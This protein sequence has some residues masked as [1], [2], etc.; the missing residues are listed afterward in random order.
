[1]LQPLICS[2]SLCYS[3]PKKPKIR[4]LGRQFEQYSAAG[5]LFLYVIPSKKFFLNGFRQAFYY[6]FFRAAL[7]PYY[8]EP[9]MLQTLK[10]IAV[11]IVK[12]I[13]I[14]C[15]SYSFFC[16]PPISSRIAWRHINTAWLPRTVSN[17]GFRS[18][19]LGFFRDWLFKEVIAVFSGRLWKRWWQSLNYIFKFEHVLHAY[20]C[21]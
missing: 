3:P 8:V 12:W 14:V 1:M 16:F 10:M 19:I 4:H 9:N 18:P 21:F 13:L 2:F 17:G 6:G 20:L 5:P 11:K 7:G 15:I